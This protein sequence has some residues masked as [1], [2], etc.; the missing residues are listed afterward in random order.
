MPGDRYFP[1]ITDT[2][3]RSKWAWSTI[4]LNNGSTG[5]CHRA[6]TSFITDD[7]D[8]FHNTS[9]KIQARELMLE[10]KWPADGCE[11]CRDIESAGGYSD[12]QFQNQ[13]PNIYPP[14]LDVDPTL[15]K[16]DPVIL[17]VFFSNACNLKCVYCSAK[18]S[19][20]IQTE[21]KKFEGA[22]LSQNNFDY[23]DNRYSELNPKFWSW[24][25]VNDE[26]SIMFVM[27]KKYKEIVKNIRKIWREE[28]KDCKL[29]MDFSYNDKRSW[30]TSGSRRTIISACVSVSVSVRVTRISSISIHKQL[31]LRTSISRTRSTMISMSRVS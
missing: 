21:D 13:V 25:E 3:C 14:A 6:S 17:E 31:S 23:I 5:S 28:L 19:S 1:I 27:N 20:S 16:V 7:F 18:F 11:Y 15:T 12:R 26:R 4:Y 22:I 10:G 2:S 9:K 29:W 8:N 30:S 24:F